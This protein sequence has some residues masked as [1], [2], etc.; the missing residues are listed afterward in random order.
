MTRVGFLSALLLALTLGFAPPVP[1]QQRSGEAVSVDSA[2]AIRAALERPPPK[3]SADALDVVEFPFKVVLLPVKLVARSLAGLAG[4]ITLSN[5]PL[6]VR[7][8]RKLPELGLTPRVR[9]IGPRSGPAL[10]LE[11]RG[12]DPFFVE[13]GL[14]IVGS[15]RHRVGIALGDATGRAGLLVAYSFRRD[16]QENFWGI[17]SDSRKADRSD[18]QREKKEGAAQGWIRLGP[19]RA[20]AGVGLESNR[21]DRGNAGTLPDLQ[22]TY[23]RFDHPPFGAEERIKLL[24]LDFSSALDL[25]HWNGFQQRGIWLNV[26]TALFRG[27]DGT[28]SKFHRVNGEFHGYLPVSSS[29][30]LALRGLVEVNVLDGGE[31]IPF[32]DLAR[33]GGSRNGPRG[34]SSGRFRDRVGVSLMAEWRYEIWEALGGRSRVEA[35]LLFDEA[36]VA[37]S[38]SEFRGSDLRPSY[39]FGMR[40]V[41]RQG[42]AL[43][44]YIAFSREGTQLEVKTEWHF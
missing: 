4:L 23:V 14:S 6:P 22:D 5:P 24:R 26:G 31:D 1:A 42:L 43:L 29:Q 27:V 17:G 40:L 32:F 15:Q 13:T 33:F 34:F 2:A 12:F 18:F 25:V 37:N 20:L 11:F 35:F 41:K 39:G 9:S 19:L 16:A 38:L 36:G 8:V 3:P 10:D 28:D 44:S 7:V 21:V 30:T